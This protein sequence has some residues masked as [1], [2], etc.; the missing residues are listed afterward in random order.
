[1][2]SVGSTIGGGIAWGGTGAAFVAASADTTTVIVQQET[3]LVRSFDLRPQTRGDGDAW[4]VLLF[5]STF[6]LVAV[7]LLF[8]WLRGKLR[9]S[10]E[11]VGV[12]VSD[13]PTAPASER[14]DPY[15]V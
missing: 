1:M 3:A 12:R 5:G 6:F 11:R 9:Q 4:V 14:L 7:G 2:M 10:A 15:P 13:Q 8:V